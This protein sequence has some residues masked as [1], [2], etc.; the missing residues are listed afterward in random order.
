MHTYWPIQLDTGED[1]LIRSSSAGYMLLLPLRAD[2]KTARLQG[3]SELGD[4]PVE[5]VEKAIQE[6]GQDLRLREARLVQQRGQLLRCG[7][8]V[9]ARLALYAAVTAAV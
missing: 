4:R 1:D 8:H 9:L 3:D 7:R 2:C 5:S 6:A